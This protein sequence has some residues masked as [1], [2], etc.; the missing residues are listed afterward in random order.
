MVNLKRIGVFSLAK[1]LGVLYAA[2]G[3][4]F[5]LFFS[6]FG[7]AFGSMMSQYGESGGMFGAMF[8]VGAIIFLPI[9]YG[10]LGFIGGALTA[11]IY[12]MIAGATGGIEVEF[13]NPAPPVPPQ[14]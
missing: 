4:I 12:N 7:L 1:V 2:L 10:V 6:L 5:G 8:G 9:F 11:W 14:A 13:E 3:L